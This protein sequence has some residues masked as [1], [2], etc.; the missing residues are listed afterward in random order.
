[1]ASAGRFTQFLD[2][3]TSLYLLATSSR[4]EGFICLCNE[5]FSIAFKISWIKGKF[6]KLIREETAFTVS[7]NVEC[8]VE[9]NLLQN[10][11]CP[12][13]SVMR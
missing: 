2:G 6:N 1:M 12:H 11:S 3:S 4:S 7:I 10:L 9:N 13:V 8:Q 5:T